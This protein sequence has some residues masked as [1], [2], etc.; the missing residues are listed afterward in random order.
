MPFACASGAPRATAQIAARADVL[1]RPIVLFM[2]LSPCLIRAR[3]PGE[4]CLK[5]ARPPLI[6][7]ICLRGLAFRNNS[8]RVGLAGAVLAGSRQQ[9]GG[10]FRILLLQA[11]HS[12]VMAVAGDQAGV[13]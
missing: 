4:G 7:I 5:F 3:A 10:H 9:G 11:P 6:Q 2:E 8:E 12:G 1:S 13:V